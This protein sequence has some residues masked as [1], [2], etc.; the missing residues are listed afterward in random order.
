MNDRIISSSRDICPMEEQMVLANSV[1][2][3]HR[4]H[5]DVQKMIKEPEDGSS[6]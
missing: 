5:G 4:A 2:M 1:P 3:V 6:V